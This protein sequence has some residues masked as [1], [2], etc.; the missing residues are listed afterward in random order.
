MKDGNR[1]LAITWTDHMD[2]ASGFARRL[3]G[4]VAYVYYMPVASNPWLLAPLRYL[5]QW[6]MAWKVLFQKRPWCVHVTN[7]PAFAA[8]NVWLYCRLSG[9][10]YI[11]DTHS[12]AL[13][14]K[15]WGW[16]LPLQRFLARR[17]AVNIV[18]QQRFKALFE[19]WGARAVILPDPPGA[20]VQLEPAQE[21]EE[22]G[23]YPILV[24]NTF[25][26]DEPVDIVLEAARALPQVRFYLTGD[27][28]LGDSALLSAA[29]QNVT[30][31]GY[32][33]REAYWRRLNACRAVMVLTTYPYSLLAGAQDGMLLGKP[34][35]LS[36]QPALCEYFT[37][38][39]LLIE[40]TTE[41]IVQ[42]VR[43]CQQREDRLR[44]EIRELAVEKRELWQTNFMELR[45][46]VGG[47]EFSAS[48]N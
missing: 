11:M 17:A 32:M 25:A 48:S 28:Q 3:E 27:T 14:S 10:F 41:G 29:P 16:S 35:I 2:R 34:L 38:G 45:R 40:N 26:P 6:V 18:D 33:E 30:L 20:P 5:V 1:A 42:G 21:A 15:K 8:L 9:A 12:P 22:D 19:S 4:D 7:P 39:A 43:E 13:Y 37:K 46:I 44:G 24:V 47:T 36:R 23:A 31:T